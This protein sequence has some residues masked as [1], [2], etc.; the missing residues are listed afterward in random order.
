MPSSSSLPSASGLEIVP[1]CWSPPNGGRAYQPRPPPR[2]HF[3]HGVAARHPGHGTPPVGTDQ[4]LLLLYGVAGGESVA[5][6]FDNDQK[7]A[8]PKDALRLMQIIND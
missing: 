6:T 4:A 3:G 5:V 7:A 1:P 8:A 2:C